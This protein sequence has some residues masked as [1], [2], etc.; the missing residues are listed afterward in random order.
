VASNQ[1]RRKSTKGRKRRA[2]TYDPVRGPR[3]KGPAAS[4]PASP[5]PVGNDPALFGEAAEDGLRML[6][7][8][9]TIPSLEPDFCDDLAAEASVTI[10]ERSV[11]FDLDP[12]PLAP[13]PA[14][15]PSTAARPADAGELPHVVAEEYA[16]YHGPVDEAVVEIFEGPPPARAESGPRR[17]KGR[18]AGHRFF[19]ALTG[20]DSG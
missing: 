10:I 15:S 14:R 2:S 5:K 20:D 4:E 11:P 16:A 17:K 19:K 18:P 3:L 8:L 7:A 12:P 6:A 13:E 1:K 9:E